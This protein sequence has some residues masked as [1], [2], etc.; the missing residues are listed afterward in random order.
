MK[1][2][3]M[4][5]FSLLATC[6][7]AS[8]DF[9]EKDPYKIVPE[10]YFTSETDARNFLT[11]IYANLGQSSFYGGD[12]ME[13]VGGD[14]LE[15]YGG[16]TGR[17]A[18][19]GLIC[20]NATSGDQAVYNFWANL[21]SGI[22]RANILLERID[23]IPGMSD[24]TRLQ[25]KSEARF[26]RAF[27]YFNLVQCWGD[28]PF[29]TASSLSAESVSGKDIARTDK[30]V[31]YQFIVTEMEEAADEQTGGLLSAREL[32][33][34]PGRISKSAAW[35]ILARVYLFWAGEHNRDGKPASDAVRN[36]YER[37]SFFGQKVMKEGHALAKNYWDPF[38]DM[39]SDKYNTTA[40]ESIWEV[41]FA[42][43]GTGDVRAEGRIGN[44]IG[45]QCSDFSSLMN[46]VGKSDPG[47]C[48]G[49]IWATP[50]LYDLYVANGDKERFTWSISPFV[51]RKINSQPSLGIVGRTFESKELYELVMSEGWY[52]E[53]SYIYDGPN[54]GEKF[55]SKKNQ[56]GDLYKEQTA[57]AERKDLCCGKFR[58]EY[59][60]TP[61]KNKNMT[62]INFPILRYSDVLLMV[63]EAENA[64]HGEPTA[65]AE[66]CLRE[67]RERAGISDLT[68][69]FTSG[70]QFLNAIKD[71]RAMELCFEYTRRFDLIRWGD[72]VEDMQ[73]QSVKAAS[74][75]K[76]W[77]QGA[78]V[79]PFFNVTATYLY[80]PIPDAERAVNKLI[81]SNNPG[82]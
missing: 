40:N 21:Y 79:A 58:R 26:L 24:Q 68:G 2:I 49:F 29:K 17:I 57:G 33:Y 77:D 78:Q 38:I 73:E 51:Y 14:D 52:G 71:E 64:Y 39:C 35:G 32:G 48:Y 72:F 61:K 11:G 56:I 67:V 12:Y 28:V 43:D 5:F 70:E 81:T 16:S 76:N 34:K 82:W 47:Y 7:L 62:Y 60:Q 54:A 63:A 31:I 46:V 45:I 80:F 23:N 37:A 75:G 15:F 19:K 9:L 74:G 30:N 18:N 20:N 69:T 27:Y 42:G 25:Y 6:S 10:N 36:Y 66:Q 55:D 59:E 41:E 1:K 65:L 53:K 22:E 50:K 44:T 4:A 3:K 8:C 13:L